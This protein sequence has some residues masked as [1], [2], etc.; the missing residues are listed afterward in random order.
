MSSS[1]INLGRI[2]RHD[3][4]SRGFA[5]QGAPRTGYSV[6]HRMDSPNVDQ[7]YT[8]GCV[9]FSGTNGLNCALAKRSRT[10]FNVL[11]P[12]SGL[13]FSGSRYLDNNDGLTNYSGAT[14]NDP[15]DWT[16]PPDDEGSSALGLMK[17]WRGLNIISGYD[18]AFSFDAFLAALQ[19]QPVLVG[20]DWYENMFYPTARGVVTIDGDNVGGHEYLANA[21]LWDAKLVGFENSWGESWGVGGRFYM[22]FDDIERLLDEGGDAAIPR[23]L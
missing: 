3:P 22:A 1:Q 4:A 15:F 10:V 17:F 23:F 12:N 16:Y 11:Y 18:W 2:R 13:R 8:S 9:G 5:Y 6:R 7:F 19:K 21:I 14:R 20:T